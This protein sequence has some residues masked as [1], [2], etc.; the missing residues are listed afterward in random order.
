MWSSDQ[1][2]SRELGSRNPGI[3]RIHQAYDFPAEAY[4]FVGLDAEAL[5]RA[6]VLRG[7]D[8]ATAPGRDRPGLRS[9]A[10]RRRLTRPAARG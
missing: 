6:G 3:Q 9:T 4:A 5:R 2:R 7:P 10:T 8:T 1:G